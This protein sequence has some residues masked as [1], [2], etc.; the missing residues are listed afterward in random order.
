MNDDDGV[1]RDHMP[2]ARVVVFGEGEAYCSNVVF[3]RG[4]RLTERPVVLFLR[5]LNQSAAG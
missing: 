3:P 2:R 1:T 4:V 5:R